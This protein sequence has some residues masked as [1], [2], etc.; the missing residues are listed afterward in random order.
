[1]VNAYNQM[2]ARGEGVLVPLTAVALTPGGDASA[3]AAMELGD[4]PEEEEP[5]TPWADRPYI[6]PAPEVCS[7]VE[8]ELALVEE[9]DG[10]K[11]GG[12]TSPRTLGSIDEWGI[13]IQMEEIGILP[14]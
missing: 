6:P 14:D 5:E 3:Y 12:S 11:R 13:W 7:D 8:S 10:E 9:A 1:M 4:F 2:R